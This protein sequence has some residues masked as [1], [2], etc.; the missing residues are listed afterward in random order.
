MLYAKVGVKK[1]RASPELKG[2]CPVCGTDVIPK[3]GSL[4]TWH[5]AHSYRQDC[6]PWSEPISPWHVSWQDI[7]LP[8]FAEVVLGPHRADILGNSD[9]VIELQHSSINSEQIAEREQFYGNMVWLFDATCR[10][11][12]IECGDR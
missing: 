9:T 2:I 3:C 4:V 1:L 11:G 5:W 10:F 8:D 6:D 7:V 12:G